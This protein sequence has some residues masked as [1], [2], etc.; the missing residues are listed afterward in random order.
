MPE[1]SHSRI[2]GREREA[3]TVNQS[4][5]RDCL[6]EDASSIP[7]LEKTSDHGPY[8]NEIN[9]HGGA[10]GPLE[11]GSKLEPSFVGA[12]VKAVSKRDLLIVVP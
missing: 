12:L 4:D 6:P 1:H 11:P 7:T 5:A 3:A 2:R 10:K 8:S 9:V